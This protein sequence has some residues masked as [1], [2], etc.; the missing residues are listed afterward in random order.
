MDDDTPTDTLASL[1]NSVAKAVAQVTQ[2]DHE[3]RPLTT[4]QDRQLL[5]MMG[6]S[7]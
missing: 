3:V 1:E 4:D 2:S 7:H 6:V 5:L